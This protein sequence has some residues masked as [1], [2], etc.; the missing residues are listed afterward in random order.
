[1]K[2]SAA[3]RMIA[4]LRYI[5]GAGIRRTYG[6]K[7]SGT[8]KRIRDISTKRERVRSLVD[9]LNQEQVSPAHFD[10]VVLDALPL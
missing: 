8:S 7:L 4:G 6:I 3:Y 2:E 1:M 10:A 5:P 9:Q